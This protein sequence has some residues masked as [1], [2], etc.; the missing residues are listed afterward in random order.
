MVDCNKCICYDAGTICMECSIRMGSGN[1][2]G[3]HYMTKPTAIKCYSCK[4]RYVPYNEEPCSSCWAAGSDNGDYTGFD[5]KEPD[6]I[7]DAVNKPKHYQIYPDM[8][9]IDVIRAVLGEE[10]FEAYCI[11]NSLKYRLRAGKK[12][13]LAQDIAK[14]EVYEGY[15][16]E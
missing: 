6:K 4:H 14:A 7:N 8:D 10:G 11:G 16:N 15:I 5:L 13:D 3:C 2:F 1:G 12:D 9:A